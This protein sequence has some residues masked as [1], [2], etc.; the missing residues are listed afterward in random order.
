MKNTFVENIGINASASIFDYNL[1]LSLGVF[2]NCN[3]KLL[4]FI[5][6]TYS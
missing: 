5:F 3:A 2:Q 4:I 6:L 1:Q